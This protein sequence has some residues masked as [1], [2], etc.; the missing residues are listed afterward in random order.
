MG[1]SFNLDNPQPEVLKVVANSPAE[2]ADIRPGD[3][4]VSVN[5][6]PVKT[7]ADFRA[8]M[9]TIRTETPISIV[10]K[11]N[12]DY[13]TKTVVP[14]IVANSYV[15]YAISRIVMEENKKVNLIIVANEITNTYNLNPN[16]IQL[17]EW[18]KAMVVQVRGDFEMGLIRA[19]QN[20][21][22]FSIIARENTEKILEELKI[23]QSGLVTE[24]I[25][26]GK[27]LGATHLLVIDLHRSR[28]PDWSTSDKTSRR[29]IDIEN[30]KT[31]ASESCEYTFW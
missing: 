11:R 25:K 16:Y 18:K 3:I 30:G 26:S 24:L 5:Q 4:F 20:Q 6:S 21:P 22:N 27:M 15:A 29:L 17:E 8:I 28:T 10:V 2:K 23:Q 13:I 12:S 9:E 7:K 31:I 19:F 1:F 14:K